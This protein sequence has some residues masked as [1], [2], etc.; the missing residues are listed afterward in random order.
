MGKLN[1]QCGVKNIMSPKIKA[2]DGE[3]KGISETERESLHLRLRNLLHCKWKV[4]GN[5]TE[6]TFVGGSCN[7]KILG[8]SIDLKFSPLYCEKKESFD[9]CNFSRR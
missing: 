1:F 5:P 8:D 4:N 6:N 7:F 2:G 3:L 9:S